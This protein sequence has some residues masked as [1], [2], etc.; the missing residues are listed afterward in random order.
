MLT[1]YLCF[2]ISSIMPEL[3][4]FNLCADVV[5]SYSKNEK[6]VIQE[7]EIKITSANLVVIYLEL[8]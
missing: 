6:G 8:K 4:S 3:N 5:E 2:I 7:E 1:T